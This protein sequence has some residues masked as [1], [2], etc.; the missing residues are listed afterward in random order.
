[1]ESVPCL[2]VQNVQRI[3]LDVSGAVQGVGFRPFVYRLAVEEGLGGFVRNAG[4][5]V[6]LEVEGPA[7]AV[8]RFQIRLRRETPGPANIQGIVRQRLEP[9]GQQGFTIGYSD[10]GGAP[11]ASILPDLAMCAACRAEL[12]DPVNRR[13]RYPFITCTHCGPR[14]SI[15]EAIP[16]DRARTAMRH[17]AMCPACQAEY[18]DPASRRFHA[19]T[20]ACPDCGPQ[21]ALQGRDGEVLARRDEALA[22]AVQALR[23]GAIVALKGLGG[24]QLLT[25][26]RNETAVALLRQRKGRPAKPFAVMVGSLGDAL[27]LVHVSDAERE[28]LMSPAA[29][30]VLLRSRDDCATPL[31]PS[32]APGNPDI[33][34]M[35]PATPLHGLLMEALGFPVVATSGNRS[36]EPMAVDGDEALARLPGIADLFLTHNRPIVNPVDDTVTRM[37]AG[38]VTALR[39]ARGMAPLVLANPKQTR[40]VL[41]LGGHM[42]NALALGW[43]GQIVLGPHIG[44]MAHTETRAAFTRSVE[45]MRSL[46]GVRSGAAACDAH[47]G[48]HTTRAASA[49]SD[50]VCPV[51]HHLAHVLSV[52]AENGLEGP[53]LG[54][55]WDGTGFGEDGTVWG[56]E[57]LAVEGAACR[58]VAHLLPFRLPGGEAAVREPRRTAIGVLHTLYG[59]ALWDREDVALLAAFAPGEQSMLR[60]MLARGINAPLTSSA[61]RLFDAVAAVLGLCQR[62]TFD[63]EAAMAVEFAARA[64]SAVH[65]LPSPVMMPEGDTLQLDW[66]PMLAAIAEAAARGVSVASLAAGFHHWLADSILEMARHAGIAQVAL[67]GGCFQNALL[68][69]RAMARLQEGGFRVYRNIRVPP[70]DGGLAVG[71][72]AYAARRMDEVMD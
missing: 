66:R 36:G 35:L 65:A 52:M 69:E 43:D 67:G 38:R 22:R 7:G 32:V 61:G 70:N 27:G 59:D 60:N 64:A 28:A 11:S 29:P 42:K 18:G 23:E 4:G 51:P 56:G 33:G 72:A 5:G 63:G 2:D 39:C 37:I 41:A 1:M 14:Y 20:N 12:F 25:D 26:A 15:I 16:Y 62:T 6:A 10:I 46:Y 45:I 13:Y 53:V 40:P 9:D 71:Q 54:A 58:R 31:A 34:L 49:I 48:Y 17:F 30:I 19:E 8:E 57:F 55:V 3:R 24:F 21:L 68:T 44:D 47:P 50:R